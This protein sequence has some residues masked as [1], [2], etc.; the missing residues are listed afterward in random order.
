MRS[1]PCAAATSLD[2]IRPEERRSGRAALGQ[3]SWKAQ[4]QAISDTL[5][6]CMGPGPWPSSPLGRAA[7]LVTGPGTDL[8]IRGHQ[9]LHQ[10]VWL[11]QQ[12][13]LGAGLGGTLSQRRQGKAWVAL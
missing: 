13:A 9:T 6:P 2:A 5:G 7:Q 12:R 1:E 3:G 11:G 8:G 10:I 4:S